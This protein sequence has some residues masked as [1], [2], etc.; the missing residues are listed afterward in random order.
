MMARWARGEAEIEQLLSRREFERITGAAANGGPPLDQA[1]TT[2]DG[3][4]CCAD[5]G[6]AG[7]GGNKPLAGRPSG[8]GK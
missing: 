8:P 6:V 4:D 5:C 3:P 7:V 2:A 1:K